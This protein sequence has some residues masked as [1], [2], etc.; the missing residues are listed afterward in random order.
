MITRDGYDEL[1]GLILAMAAR[2]DMHW[3]FRAYRVCIPFR[4]DRDPFLRVPRRG[5]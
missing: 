3:Q 2:D 1:V 5:V 4:W